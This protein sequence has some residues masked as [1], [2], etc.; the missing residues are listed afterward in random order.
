[1]NDMNEV[2]TGEVSKSSSLADADEEDEIMSAIL[3]SELHGFASFSMD[4]SFPPKIRPQV[5]KKLQIDSE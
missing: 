1:M 4:L 2:S 5:R 3:C